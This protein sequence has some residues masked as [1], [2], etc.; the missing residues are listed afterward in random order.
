MHFEYFDS[1][2]SMWTCY[3]QHHTLPNVWVL[4]IQERKVAP[5]AGIN[6]F[7]FFAHVAGVSV[8]HG[9]AITETGTSVCLSRWGWVACNE[10]CNVST[11]SS[12]CTVG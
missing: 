12:N 6:I 11:C 10:R 2:F 7:F 5:G 3:D 4:V 9:A 1:G 8:S